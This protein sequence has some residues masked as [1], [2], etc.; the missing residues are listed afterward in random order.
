MRKIEYLEVHKTPTGEDLVVKMNIYEPGD[1][2][3]VMDF[4]TKW[5]RY[6]YGPV[7]T[8][9]E[10][11]S[12]E[13]WDINAHHPVYYNL[14][15]TKAGKPVGVDGPGNWHFDEVHETEL[16]A[17]DDLLLFVGSNVNFFE[18]CVS[19]GEKLTRKDLRHFEKSKKLQE[20]YQKR[21][22]DLTC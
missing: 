13:W 6:K 5:G 8:R 12:Q 15:D 3:W 20:F 10:V 7:I 14:K 11:E 9:L 22:Q 17:V 2:V 19:L 1:F 18:E 4:D 16:E 21:R